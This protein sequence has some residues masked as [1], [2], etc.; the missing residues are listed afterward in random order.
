M[1][2]RTLPVWTGARTTRGQTTATSPGAVRTEEHPLRLSRGASSTLRRSGGHPLAR[3]PGPTDRRPRRWGRSLAAL[4]INIYERAAAGVALLGPESEKLRGGAAALTRGSGGAI[5]ASGA[6]Q[7][8]RLAGSTGGGEGG[9]ERGLA[10]WWFTAEPGARAGS[11]RSRSGHRSIGPAAARP[12]GAVGA[13]CRGTHC[14][15]PGTPQPS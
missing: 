7:P 12:L 8:A 3:C 10:G 1:H 15:V 2:N 5:A 4:A 6:W 9:G 11:R 14:L 13:R